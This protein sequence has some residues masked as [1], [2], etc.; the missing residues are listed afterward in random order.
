MK[1]SIS[2]ALTLALLSVPAAAAAGQAE[3]IADIVQ[4][5]QQVL[6]VDDQGRGL[7]GRVELASA[8]VVRVSTRAGTE[9]VATDRIVRIEKPDGL[10][11]GTLIGLGVGLGLG[12]VGA[13]LVHG[14]GAQSGQVAAAIVSNALACT[15]LGTGI[16]AVFNNRRTL[17]ERGRR[18]QTRVAP[19]VR[20]GVRAAVVAVTW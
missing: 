18:L 3:R 11:N 19:V 4:A 15:L 2:A 20:S 10:K 16:D 13:T 12:V 6:I 7:E 8:A 1:F 14:E 9:D 17:Y 5:G